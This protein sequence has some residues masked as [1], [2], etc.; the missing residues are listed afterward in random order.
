MRKVKKG[1][2]EEIKQLLKEHKSLTDIKE[3]VQLWKAEGYNVEELEEMISSVYESEQEGDTSIPSFKETPVKRSNKAK[4]GVIGAV[5]IV[6]AFSLVATSYV[7]MSGMM[8]APNSYDQVPIMTFT[9][10]D[11]RNDNSLVVISA[12]PG[13]LYWGDIDIMIDGHK[14]NHGNYGY[15]RA[16]D[17]IDISNIVGDG[18]YSVSIRHI[19]TNT[20][21]GSWD[22]TGTTITPITPV[23]TFSQT[24]QATTN[25]LTVISADPGDLDWGD[26]VLKVVGAT[27]A[28][29]QSGNVEAGDIITIAAT[30]DYT[31]TIAHT[32]SNTL[33]GSW[34]FT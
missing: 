2:L 9:K 18:T 24:D 16:G 21:I 1:Q 28:H 8:I 13:T 25:T 22:F 31:V 33:I 7:Y 12:D 15:V 29:G 20:L 11:T 6:I 26:L 30:G 19:S 17:D 23:I 14:Y 5:V 3:K 32:P 10:T 4:Y 27:T 34:D